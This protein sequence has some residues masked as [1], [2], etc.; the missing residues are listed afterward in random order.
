M[1]VEDFT[2]D[3]NGD[4]WFRVSVSTNYIN[5]EDTRDIEIPYNDIRDLEGFEL[6]STIEE[7]CKPVMWEM[8][9]WNFKSIDPSEVDD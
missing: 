8:I 6:E 7:Y 3:E 9:D 4:V 1:K 5:C 2:P